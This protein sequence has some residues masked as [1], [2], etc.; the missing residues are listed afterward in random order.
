M[1]TIE[2]EINQTKDFYDVRIKAFVNLIFT[3][4]HLLKE[5]KFLQDNFGSSMQQFNVLK[6]I[7]GKHP[8]PINPGKIKEVM[9]EKAPDLTRLID[10]LVKKELVKRWKSEN[11]R[12]QINI[13]LTQKGLDLLEEMSPAVE[14]HYKEKFSQ[15]S[16]EE[17]EQL[18]TLLDK[19]RY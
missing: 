17:A 5:N 14:N 16:D 15:L 13:T 7:K 19:I 11:N 8:E 3:Y 1:T 12:R 2:K 6:I 9:V 4:N 18:S 10:R